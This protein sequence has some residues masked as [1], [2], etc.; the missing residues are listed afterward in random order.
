MNILELLNFG[1]NK[2]KF[3][4]INTSKLDAEL[5]LSKVLESKREK[6]LIDQHK[7]IQ[8]RKIKEFYNLIERRSLKEPLAYILEEKEFFSKPFKV[9]HSTLI[10][11]PETELIVE[12][13]AK[14]YK[15]KSVFILDIGTGSGCIL[16]SLLSELIHSKGIGIDICNKALLVAKENVDKNKVT[17]RLKLMRR[18]FTELYNFRFDL[19]VSNPPY[20]AKN[21]IKNL[22][23][24]IKKYEPLLAL[25]GGNDGVDV[26]KK[27]IYKA[28]E[29]LKIKGKLALEIGNKQYLKV[30]KI[31]KDNN[32]K[33]EHNIKDYKE[34]IRCLIS[35]LTK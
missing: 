25:D 15:D 10:P 24:D 14:I 27:V 13:L 20:I 32:F 7:I 35:S 17:R 28:R 33:I 1:S 8:M 3:K 6:I 21:H 11:R 18:S 23:D 34:N 12:K 22:E 2:L 30:S 31:L 16:I 9:D 29:I 4:N 19:I 26:I 5:L